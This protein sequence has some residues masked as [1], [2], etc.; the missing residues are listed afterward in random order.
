MVPEDCLISE[1][2]SP[3]LPAGGGDSVDA[4]GTCYHVLVRRAPGAKKGDY[5]VVLAG[6]G[7]LGL[8]ALR[9]AKGLEAAVIGVDVSADKLEL[10][11]SYGADYVIDGREDPSWSKPVPPTIPKERRADHV[12]SGYFVAASGQYR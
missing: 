11:Q 10:M 6:S 3:L 9:M 4:L 7:G 1:T 5:L 12:K 2:A 8:H